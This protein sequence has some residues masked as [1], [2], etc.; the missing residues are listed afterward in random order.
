MRVY[1]YYFAPKTVVLR[2][3]EG[4]TNPTITG[5][6]YI[7]VRAQDLLLKNDNF[8]KDCGLFLQT[9]IDAMVAQGETEY[10]TIILSNTNDAER[11]DLI[12]ELNF[13]LIPV[14]PA[15]TKSPFDSKYP[16]G[17]GYSPVL[18]RPAFVEK[19]KAKRFNFGTEA[20]PIVYRIKPN[21]IKERR[22]KKGAP[23]LG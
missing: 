11:I 15:V 2:P 6:L 19:L 21:S 16:T 1:S 5:I 22:S 14:D 9:D 8:Y 17:I 7:G 10:T 18:S 4:E 13:T 20:T 12:E 23:T 3:A